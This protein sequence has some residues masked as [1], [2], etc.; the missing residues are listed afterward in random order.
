MLTWEWLRALETTLADMRSEPSHQVVD[1][2]IAYHWSQEV[3]AMGK[4]ANDELEIV[5][6]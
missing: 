4:L 1:K 6:K 3:T 2:E 5:Y